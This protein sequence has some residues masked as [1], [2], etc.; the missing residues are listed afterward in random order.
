MLL[1]TEEPVIDQFLTGR[2][3][4]PIGMSEEKDEATMSRETELGI[5]VD[6]GEQSHG[7]TPQIQ[8]SPG[9]PPRRARCGTASGSTRCGRPAARDA[10]G[11]H[12]GVGRRAGG[13]VL[14][15]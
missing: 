13:G 2:R 9:L 5:V 3:A 14:T 12:R 6:P 4:G 10:A 1:T 8:P 11:D 7:L 15:R